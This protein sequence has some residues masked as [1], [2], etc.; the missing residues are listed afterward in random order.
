MPYDVV[1]VGGGPAGLSAALALGRARKRVLLCDAG[2]RRNAAAEHI[3][4]FVTRDGTPP[5]EFREI[6]RQQLTAYSSVEVRDVRIESITGTRGAFQVNLTTDTVEA[7]RIL[8][9]T[10][11]I[12]ERLGLDGFRELWGH[13]IFQC[14][15]CHGWE[16]RDQKWA[17]LARGVESLHF[18]LQLRGWTREV[19]VFTG[20]TFDVPEPT[21]ARFDTMGIRLETRPV[22]RL[23]A[24]ENR[25]EGIELSDGTTIPCEV[26]FAHPPQR[27]VDLV[28]TLG[29]GLDEEGYVRVDPMTRETSVPGI[30]AGGD[31]QTRMQ[32]AVFAAAAGVHAAAMLNHELTVELAIAEEAGGRE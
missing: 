5:S 24:R 19:V 12:D 1:I 31:L 15:Y 20:G 29:V 32:G 14:P 3:H 17:Y 7:R 9:C 8:L 6:G 28:R 18:P 27:Q 4:N 13:S 16:V 21:R 22:A 10:G 11:M 2:T 25:L 23:V 30:Y 26:L